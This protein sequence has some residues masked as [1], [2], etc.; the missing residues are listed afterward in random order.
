MD[1]GQAARW[2]AWGPTV[3]RVIIGFIFVMHGWDK[4]F[5]LGPE[6]WT[7]IFEA[8]GI[9]AARAAVTLVGLVEIV[10]GLALIAGVLT[11]IAAALLAVDM[12]VAIL[13]VGVDGGFWVWDSGVVFPLAMLAATLCLVLT[14]P[15]RAALDH[16]LGWRWSGEPEAA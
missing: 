10:A 14:G 1:S 11:R 5:G 16:Q 2:A 3:L 8:Q 4:F 9:P 12:L 13:T 15:G 7:G 6:A